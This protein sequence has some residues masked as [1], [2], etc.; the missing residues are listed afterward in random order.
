MSS[1]VSD[2]QLNKVINAEHW[3]PFQVLGY[4]KVMIRGEERGLIRAFL[5]EAMKVELITEDAVYEMKRA[6]KDGLFEHV[7]DSTERPDYR[8][9]LTNWDNHS[10]ELKDPYI[11]S[12]VITDFDMHLFNEGNHYRIYEKLGAHEITHEGEK[13]VL[14]AVW[15]PNAQRVSVIGNFNHWDGRHNQMRSRGSS[16][17]WE[18]FIPGLCTG[19]IYKYELK[20]QNGDILE[21]SDPFSFYCEVRPR[22]ASIVY[23]L[24]N[25]SWNDEEYLKR[26]DELN[27]QERPILIYEVHPGSWK[28]KNGFDYLSYRE[29]AN[30]LIGYV[31]EMGYTHIQLMP[32]AE[33]PF[34]GSW[35]Y[36]VTGY[37]APSSRFGTPDDFCYFVDQCHQHDLGVIVDWVP[38][39]FPTD[40]FGLARF[41]GTALYEHEDPR[42]GLHK[43]WTTYIFNY[44][45]NEVRN[46]LISN[47]LFWLDYY[48]LDGLRVDAVASMLYLDYARKD[49][50][51]IP[52]QYGGNENLEAVSFIKRLNE[53]VYLEH[54]GILMIA[55]ESTS[56]SGVSR[57]THSGGLG[58]GLKWNM[59]WMNDFLSYMEK[60]PIHRKYHHN[61]LTFSMIYAYTENFILVLSHDEV[62]HGKKSLL[63]KMPGDDWQKFANLRLAMGFMYS[64]P[65]KKLTFMG[66]ELGQWDEWN[67]DKSLDWHLLQWD[68]H[69]KTQSYFKAL[70]KLY[71]DNPA[72]YEID[73][74][75]TGFEWINCEDKENSV[76]SFI[77]HGKK[78][79]DMLVIVAN[80]TPIIRENYR[81]GVPAHC[82]WEELLNSDAKEFY[83]SGVGNLGGKWSDEI[84]WD[85]RPYSFNITLP[86]LAI[87]V[88]RPK[89]DQS[90]ADD[91][92]RKVQ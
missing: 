27:Q 90:V 56:W 30:E 32:V 89:Y 8:Y 23:S 68:P 79:E 19:E 16:G 73:F 66:C 63:S 3:D 65:G 33:H 54:P 46:F 69:Y 44:G 57:P 9:R 72:L 6:H 13:G 2:V 76:V 51:W 55:E 40:Q 47:A 81:V 12:P 58:F 36:Q 85:N 42:K 43:D 82:F 21:K 88:F 64:H 24:G 49:G 17:I 35:G 14:F 74:E 48:H 26:R 77:R 71:R 86:P 10:W 5:P 22:T 34:D 7:L 15:A 37:F 4:H 75:H 31:K 92:P 67:H 80:F 91:S 45:R 53:Q 38:A 1:N 41:D 50:E 87:L 84:G 59:G 70:N 62:V 39:H 78:K 60:E 11:F 20:S 18:L 29:M 52:N 28:R 83:G 61:N 25:Y